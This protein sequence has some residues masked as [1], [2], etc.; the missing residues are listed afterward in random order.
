MKDLYFIE[1]SEHIFLHNIHLLAPQSDWWLL[2]WMEWLLSRDSQLTWFG[3]G[4]HWWRW[5]NLE[6]WA[7]L[8]K[9][10]EWQQNLRFWHH[11]FA[12]ALFTGDLTLFYVALQFHL[13]LSDFLTSLSKTY[14]SYQRAGGLV[15]KSLLSLSKLIRQC[16]FYVAYFS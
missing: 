16:H 15:F 9:G 6:W 5:S 8:S 3:P 7:S 10:L 2:V 12:G 1:A 4:S 11:P 14:F 13:L